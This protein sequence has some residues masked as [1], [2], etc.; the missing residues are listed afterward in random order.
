[1]GSKRN[2]ENIEKEY[3]ERNSMYMS[4]NKGSDERY[5]IDKN[6]EERVTNYIELLKLGKLVLQK[7]T[8]N[9]ER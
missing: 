6:D 5:H 1:M 9:I 3:D 8:D 4:D 7:N 2:D